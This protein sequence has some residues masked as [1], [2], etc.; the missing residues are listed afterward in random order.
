MGV[1]HS[2]H[3]WHSAHTSCTASSGRAGA[4]GRARHSSLQEQVA[5]NEDVDMHLRE[6]LTFVD[7]NGT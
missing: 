3:W 4:G 7:R 6:G 1:G 5:M 2:P